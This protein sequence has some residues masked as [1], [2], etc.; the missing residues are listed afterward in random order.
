MVKSIWR[1]AILAAFA[2]AM[3]PKAPAAAQTVV[4]T[5][6]SY[7]NCS[8]G[9]SPFTWTTVGPNSSEEQQV[10]CNPGDVAVGGGYEIGGTTSLPLPTGVLA[11]VPENSFLFSNTTA[12]GWQ[13]VLQN[14]NT[15][16]Q[17]NKCNSGNPPPPWLAQSC[18]S[19][20]FRVCVSCV[21][22]PL[23]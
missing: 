19:I 10:T 5:V 8:T 2:W 15:L 20:Q 7:V 22:P 16:P 6:N 14:V 4:G 12:I 17:C 13:V 9:F 1:L 23:T 18:P 11:I 21:T 3:I